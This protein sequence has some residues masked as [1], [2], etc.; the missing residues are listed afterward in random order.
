[1]KAKIKLASLVICLML[2]GCMDSMDEYYIKINN[3]SD[4]SIYLIISEDDKMF[5]YEKYLLF[6]RIKKGEH[7]SKIDLTGFNMSDE[8]HPNSLD[9]SK[10][11][12]DWRQSIKGIKDKKVRFYIVEKDSVVKYGWKYIN[13]SII[14]NKKYTL[15]FD[16]LRKMKWEITYE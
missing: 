12:M 4:E 2:L 1:M 16:D 6:E 15:T 8:I 14:Y 10:G 13:D 7:V 5:D 9:K 3:K 11:Y